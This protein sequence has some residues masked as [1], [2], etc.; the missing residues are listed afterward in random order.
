MKEFKLPIK[1]AWQVSS[2]PVE[3]VAPIVSTEAPSTAPTVIG[4]TW[5]DTKSPAIY[6]ST[7]IASVSDWRLIWD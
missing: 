5:I 4:A 6:M 7:G 2:K 3:V 1:K